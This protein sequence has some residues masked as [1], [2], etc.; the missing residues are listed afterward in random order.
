[1][2]YIILKSMNTQKQSNSYKL[3]YI[4]NALFYKTRTTLKFK[5]WPTKYLTMHFKSSSFQYHHHQ[6]LSPHRRLAVMDIQHPLSF[7]LM[8]YSAKLLLIHLLMLPSHLYLRLPLV[9]LPSTFPSSIV[10]S[11]V[12]CLL[13]WPKY[14]IC[15]IFISLSSS[16]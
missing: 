5:I 7:A 15:L 8:I 1:M 12:S 6:V 10:F 14:F 3:Y 9:L 11:I 2:A 16:F 13:M 4:F